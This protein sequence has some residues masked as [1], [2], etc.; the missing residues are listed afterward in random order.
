MKGQVIK[1]NSRERVNAA[2]NHEITDRIPFDLGGHVC[3]GVHAVEMIKLRNKL[4]L[5]KRLPKVIEPMMLVAEVE[6]DLR[7]KLGADCVPITPRGTLL[8]YRNENYKPWTL[9]NGVEILMGGDFV[10]TKNPDGSMYSY[11]ECNASLPP[12]VKMAKD[13]LYF[14]NITR[15]EDL[16]AKKDWNGREDYHNQYALY[17][18]QDIKDI[19][20]QV[21]FYWN[22]TEYAL[23]GGFY[24]MGL[25]DSL[26]I[27]G[28][29]INQPKGIRELSDWMMYMLI[30]PEYIKEFFEY[31]TELGLENIK[32][33]YKI[34]GNKLSAIF[35]T[36]TDFG[37]QNGMLISRDLFRELFMPFH[38]KVNKWIHENTD[39][40][41]LIHSCGGVSN[42]I[43]DLIEAGF[44][45]INPVQISAAGMEAAY[46]KDNFGDKLAFWGGGANPQGTIMTGSPE[47]VYEETKRNVEILGKNGG[48][49]AGHVHNLQYSVPVENFLAEVQA[50]KDAKPN[51]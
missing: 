35:T 3:S 12:S 5:E 37:S 42:I 1:M 39:W 51:G 2:L 4:G 19:E 50:I 45:V 31:Q 43:P 16:D 26:H 7:Q 41:I 14:D 46:L 32:T 28:P 40:K 9:P 49:I 17:S 34:A 20:E 8:G 10:Y 33:F 44:D 13:G 29:R 27:P 30:K 25:G 11:P 18:E 24:N 48:F 23:I 22:N 15:Q 21:D 36:G 38:V 6:E 47:E